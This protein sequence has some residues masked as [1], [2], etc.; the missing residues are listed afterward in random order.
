MDEQNKEP[1]ADEIACQAAQIEENPTDFCVEAKNNKTQDGQA[2]K[3]SETAT[4]E[5]GISSGEASQEQN[6]EETASDEANEM[7]QNKENQT[8][9]E[10]ATSQDAQCGE[11]NCADDAEKEEEEEPQK[12]TF[13]LTLPQN[14][15]EIQ[16]KICTKRGRKLI[17]SPHEVIFEGSWKVFGTDKKN[18]EGIRVKDIIDAEIKE[19]LRLGILDKFDGLKSSEIKE[20]YENDIVYEFAEQEFRKA[21]IVAENG[22]LKVYIYDW[23]RVG[24]HHVGTIDET[25]AAEFFKYAED[26][27]KYSFDICAIITGGKGK[28]VTKL[29]DGKIKITKEK[30]DPIGIELDITVIDRKD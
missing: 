17:Y 9:N 24:M 25:A 16:Q 8:I 26:K 5:S 13:K 20:E 2:T 14:M 27:E 10:E 4:E 21:G 22:K 12:E 1:I 11:Q 29:D 28:R 30:G 15:E 7:T 23:D 18:E 3:T 6:G 19:G